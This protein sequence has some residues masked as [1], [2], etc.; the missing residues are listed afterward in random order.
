MLNKINSPLE[1][2]VPVAVDGS[3]AFDAVDPLEDPAEF[4]N[5]PGHLLHCRFKVIHLL[6]VDVLRKLGEVRHHGHDSQDAGGCFK[7]EFVRYV[8]KRV[9][10]FHGRVLFFSICLDS[11]QAA[12]ESVQDAADSLNKRTYFIQRALKCPDGIHVFPANRIHD[13]VNQFEQ[14]SGA[15]EADSDNANESDQGCGTF[16]CSEWIKSVS[17]RQ[18]VDERQSCGN[19]GNGNYYGSHDAHDIQSAQ[20]RR[21]LLCFS[22]RLDYR[23]KKRHNYSDR[24]D[25]LK[26]IHQFSEK[27]FGHSALC[28][29]NGPDHLNII[30]EIQNGPDHHAQYSQGPDSCPHFALVNGCQERYGGRDS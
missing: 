19:A 6:N 29:L 11:E 8:C 20:F 3:N 5:A 14:S 17:A 22:E 23:R 4:K 21:K 1:V 25:Y 24:A 28:C 18:T 27:P 9:Q 30:G 2:L 26:C 13:S 15:K 10:V 16:D 12:E 7:A